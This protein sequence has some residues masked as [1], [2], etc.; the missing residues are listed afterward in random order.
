MS[1]ARLTLNQRC[2]RGRRLFLAAERQG[3]IREHPFYFIRRIALFEQAHSQLDTYNLAFYF[4]LG[5]ALPLPF[6]GKPQVYPAPRASLVSLSFRV[7]PVGRPP[8]VEQ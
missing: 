6:R 2:T 5:F 3:T 4:P 8:R 1:A 7:P